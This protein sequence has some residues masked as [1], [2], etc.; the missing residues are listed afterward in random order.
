M[1]HVWT[2]WGAVLGQLRPALAAQHRLGKRRRED[3]IRLGL[4]CVAEA[5]AGQPERGPVRRSRVRFPGGAALHCWGGGAAYGP[6]L[7]GRLAVSRLLNSSF[8][9]MAARYQ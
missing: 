8:F 1:K 6:R 9:T 5:F 7:Q 2:Y 3:P 4:S